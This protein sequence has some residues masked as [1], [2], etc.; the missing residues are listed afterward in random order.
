MQDLLAEFVDTSEARHARASFSSI[1]PNYPSLQSD[2]LSLVQVQALQVL[3]W[4]G[5]CSG[6]NGLW[7]SGDVWWNETKV[8]AKWAKRIWPPASNNGG[9][10]RGS[11][12]KT[13]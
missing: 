10:R 11:R 2:S 5:C 9:G 3:Y 13:G 4:L 8:E 7:L 1:H 12:A 6:A